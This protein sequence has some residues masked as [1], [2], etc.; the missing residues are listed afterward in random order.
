MRTVTKESNRYE[1]LT[2][3]LKRRADLKSRKMMFC[4]SLGGFTM[5]EPDT[6]TVL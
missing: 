1:H 3:S 6:D 4:W 5:E 2:W